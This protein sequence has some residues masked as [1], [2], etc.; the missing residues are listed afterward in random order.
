MMFCSCLHIVW[1]AIEHTVWKLVLSLSI[2]NPT[3]GSMV[4]YTGSIPASIFWLDSIGAESKT[5]V[6][7]LLKTSARM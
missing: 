3:F 7:I 6:R 4:E 1:V 2:F 5:M